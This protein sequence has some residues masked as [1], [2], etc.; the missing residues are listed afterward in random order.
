LPQRGHGGCLKTVMAP[1]PTDDVL[2]APATAGARTVRDAFGEVTLPAQALWGANTERARQHFA[3]GARLM[4]LE[5][6]RALVELKRAAATVNARL[7]ALDQRRAQAIVAAADEVLGGGHDEQFPLGPWQSGSAT[8]T[9]QNVNEVLASLA[10][11]RFGGRGDDAAVHAS[12]HVNAGQSSNDMVPSAMHVATL[13]A[14]RERLLPA[15]DALLLTLESQAQAHAGI[16]KLGR[17]H[18]QDAVPMSLGQEIGAWRSQLLFGRHAVAQA[19]P[20]L[21]S[22]AVGGTAVGSGLN[23]HPRF[24]QDVCV[25][26]SSRTGFEFVR[27]GD[28]FAAQSGQEPLLLLHG[29]LRVLA[30]SLHKVANDV[31]LLAS[32]PRGGIGELRLPANEPGSSIMPGK[33]NP[34]QCEALVMVCCQIFGNDA[35]VAAGVAGGQLQL[36]ACKPLIF[37]NVL[38]SVRLLADAMA[39]FDAHA[40]RGLAADTPRI[41][42]LLRRSLMLVTALAPH[43]GYERAAQIAQRAHIRDST[44]REAALALGVSAHDFDRWVD[45]ARMA[46][47]SGVQ[48][49]ETVR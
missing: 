7:G 28:P 35:A 37:V 18:L 21:H 39:S 43:I 13:Q 47:G 23:A 10:S 6:V 16:V 2:K 44:L 15:L 29:A 31:R 41:N 34:T 26:L 24:G 49:G 32:G 17:T 36:N 8:Q 11:A 14:L 46:A 12:D 25:E 38:D 48:P 5:L 22:L 19:M 4:P 1:R 42:E 30:A 40:M 3:I 27:A 33:V 45:P 20:A 9:H